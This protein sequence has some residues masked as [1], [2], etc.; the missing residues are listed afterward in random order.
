MADLID[1]ETVLKDLEKMKGLAVEI[2]E[3]RPRIL[4][5]QGLSGKDAGPAYEHAYNAFVAEDYEGAQ[6]MFTALLL[7]DMRE[8][9]FQIGLA[10]SLEAQEKFSEALKFYALALAL[11][12]ADD[13]ALLF[14]AGKCLL[15]TQQKEEACILFNMAARSNPTDTR[16]IRAMERS[17]KILAVLAS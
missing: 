12:G 17:R 2:M 9:S 5:S 16:G 6:G 11:D 8:K 13:P 14:R 3:N 1:R 4:E 10:A 7:M 15:S